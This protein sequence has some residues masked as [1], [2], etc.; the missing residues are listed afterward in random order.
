M[1]CCGRRFCVLSSCQGQMSVSSQHFRQN[2]NI[3][4]FKSVFEA[5]RGKTHQYLTPGFEKNRQ[6]KYICV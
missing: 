4:E 6:E 5:K 2:W 1:S 3:V